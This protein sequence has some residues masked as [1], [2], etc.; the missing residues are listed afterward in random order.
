MRNLKTKARLP[1]YRQC[2]YLQI[3]L[4]NKVR[5]WSHGSELS[6][7]TDSRDVGELI[8]HIDQFNRKKAWRWPHK[9]HFFFSDLHADAHAFVDSLVASGGVRRTGISL[10]DFALT[11]VG[12]KAVFVI[13]GD[14]FDKGPSSLQLLRTIR[15]L[16]EVGAKVQILAGN[17]DV[18]V[19]LGMTAV[20]HQPDVY[21]E[22]FFIRTGPK[23]I[24][25]LKEIIDE[26]VDK[27]DLKKVPDK[28]TARQC[29]LPRDAWFEEFPR[30]AKDYLST[31]QI[32]RELDRV[33]K[34]VARFE[35][36]LQKNG[37]NLRQ[38]CAAAY[39]WQDL[40]LK[41]DGEFYW[42]YKRM[43]LVLKSG[44][45]LFVHAG[46]DNESARRLCHEGVHA[47]NKD[48]RKSL[49]KKPFDFYYGALCNMIR[50]KYRKVD[51][52]L[53]SQG[54]RFIRRAGFTA[55]IHGHRNLYHGQRMA[56]RKGL[57]SFECDVT[58]DC[59]SRHKEGLKGPGG[60][61]TIIE[62]QGYILGI[63]TD[64]P[65][66]KFFHPELTLRQLHKINPKLRKTAAS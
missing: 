59:H 20:D 27:D 45:L 19:L 39:K 48:F 26:Y 35:K 37:L 33:G 61:V 8:Q 53:S 18:R 2:K 14:C 63:S 57:L 36:V 28:K 31:A 62:P 21:N 66:A 12:E 64:Y 17:H 56:L 65:F 42:F 10:T 1:D 50:T 46:L 55:I 54:T 6:V 15:F 40:F 58:V 41:P 3:K 23:I 34:K 25:L 49:R 29:L 60:G 7:H 4:P 51:R 52:R 16:I 30:V 44:S 5:D 9:R 13:G 43:R 47:L 22:H 38:V 24:P 32:E 11:P